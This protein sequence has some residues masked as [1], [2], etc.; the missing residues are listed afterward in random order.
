VEAIAELNQETKPEPVAETVHAF[1]N[2]SEQPSAKSKEVTSRV[3]VVTRED[4]K[5]IFFE[6]QDRDQK[7]AWVH[8]NYIRKQ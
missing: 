8:R 3:R 1:L 5:N 7:D 4:D 2:D 6:T